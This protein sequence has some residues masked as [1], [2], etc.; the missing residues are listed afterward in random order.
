MA[1]VVAGMN[2][3]DYSDFL[4]R[5]A[6]D[7]AESQ[8]ESAARKAQVDALIGPAPA[9]APPATAA[10]PTMENAGV[11]QQAQQGVATGGGVWHEAPGY[12]SPTDRRIIGASD[13]PVKAYQEAIKPIEMPETWAPDPSNPDLLISNRGNRKYVEA[14]APNARERLANAYTILDDPNSSETDKKAAQAYIDSELKPETQVNIGEDKFVGELGKKAA[15]SFIER[16]DKAQ[17]AYDSI[18]DNTESV[19]LLNSGIVSGFGADWILGTGKALEQAGLIPAGGDAAETMSN[20]E[21]YLAA[22][23]KA[24]AQTITNFG[25]GTG[26]SDKDLEFARDLAAGRIDMTESAMRKIIAMHDRAA[27]RLIGDVNKKLD[28][29]GDKRPPLLTPFELPPPI[30]FAKPSNGDRVIAPAT[31]PKGGNTMDDAW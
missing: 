14:R 20:T 9:A 30:D 25:A 24:V 19:Q 26:L 18:A 22:R 8:R 16:Y 31:N 5:N 28:L 1:E 17:L 13:D 2:A 7:E 23:G 15:S 4:K 3:D 6:L 10:G 21:A 29:L 27:R 12:I 11:A